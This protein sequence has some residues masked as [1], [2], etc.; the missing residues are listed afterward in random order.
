MDHIVSPDVA[1]IKSSQG[2][3][4]TLRPDFETIILGNAVRSDSHVIIAF[5]AIDRIICRQEGTYLLR[6]LAFMYS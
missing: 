3:I 6:Q 4:I 2:L 5:K 1:S